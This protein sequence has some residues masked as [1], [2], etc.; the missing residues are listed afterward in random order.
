MVR[1][2]KQQ[3]HVWVDHRC[4][5]NFGSVM[6]STAEP[7]LPTCILHGLIT[8]SNVLSGVC[9][10]NTGGT[11]RHNSAHASALVGIDDT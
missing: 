2:S 11:A 8:A 10:A 1:M 4:S 7:V 6:T 9:D 5:V 3:P